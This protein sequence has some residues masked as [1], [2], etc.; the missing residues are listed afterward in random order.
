[1]P[2]LSP[3][4]SSHLCG[5]KQSGSMNIDTDNQLTGRIIGCAIDVHREL[6][7]GLE[8]AAY[9]EALASKLTLAGLRNL[10]QFPLPVVYKGEPIDCG[11]RLDLLVEDRLPVEL[12]AVEHMLPVFEAQLLTYQR[13]GGFPLG[14]LINFDVAVLKQ[15]LRR[16]AAT[17][18][19]QT[20]V[21]AFPPADQP[22]W[23]DLSGHIL[24]AA[25]EV[26]RHLGPGLLR[27]AYEACL[28]HELSQRGLAFERP[29]RFAIRSDGMTLHAPAEVP[30]LVAGTA[31]VYCLSVAELTPLHSARLRARLQQGDWP[32]GLLLNFHAPAL[33]QSVRR[34]EP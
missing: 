3:C 19:G 6:G 12:K 4:A 5:D 2:P 16:M 10:R 11:Y 15:G 27:S 32:Y 33:S 7:P 8:E 34:I 21:S 17:R 20:G 1:M 31:P 26:H 13:L 25:I 29:K 22:K 24:D 18:T 14:L 23:D 28:G 30:M 9:E